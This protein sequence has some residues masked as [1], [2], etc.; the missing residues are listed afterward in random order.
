MPR[1]VLHAVHATG[2]VKVLPLPSAASTLRTHLIWRSDHC[3][4]SCLAEE[5]IG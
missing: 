5:V 4:S 3:G 1:S 2:Q